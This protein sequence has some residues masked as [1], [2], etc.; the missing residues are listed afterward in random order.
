MRKFLKDESGA[1]AAE[2]GLI[3]AIVTVGTVAAVTS[4]SEVVSTAINEAASCISGETVNGQDCPEPVPD[5]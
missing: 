2:Y 5:P 1:A 3:L 4:L